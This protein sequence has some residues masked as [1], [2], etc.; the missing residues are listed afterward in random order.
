M[1]I[2]LGMPPVPSAPLAERRLSRQ[3][4]VGSVPVGGGAPVS[5]QSM[6]TTLTV[7]AWARMF[8]PA[9]APANAKAVTD[10]V[11][12]ALLTGG[13]RA[14]AELLRTRLGLDFARSWAL[15]FLSAAIMPAIGGT[16]L[17]CWGLS[18]LKLIDL[19]QRG[20]YE[21]FGA[22]VAVLGPGMHLLLP[23]PL[24][25]LRPVEFGAIHSVAVGA[26]E[27]ALEEHDVLAGFCEVGRE[28]YAALAAADDDEVD[29][30][31]YPP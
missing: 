15:S 13:P 23:W 28:R 12:A 19:G 24:G 30:F 4:M 7:R 26:D 29:V 27:T 31:H 6:A 21:R 10:S 11:F 20:I 3:I 14:P 17:L 22:P 16:L 9:P 18:G 8:L 5:V 2:D 1:S 25:R